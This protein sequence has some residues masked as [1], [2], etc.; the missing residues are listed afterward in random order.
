MWP[1]PIK[2]VNLVTFTGEIF[3]GKRNL[4]SSDLMRLVGSAIK[5][6]AYI[7]KHRTTQKMKF[8][9]K[10]FFS[11]CDQIRSKRNP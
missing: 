9:I 3:N 11:K 6:S 7:F 5:N 1:N 10:D 4:L 2:I 8:F